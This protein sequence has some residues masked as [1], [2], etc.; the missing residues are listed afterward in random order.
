M[1]SDLFAMV[2]GQPSYQQFRTAFAA[3]K[4]PLLVVCGAGLSAPAGLPLWGELRRKLEINAKSKVESLNQFGQ[5]YHDGKLQAAI[6]TNDSWV[7]LKLISEILGDATFRNYVVEYLTPAADAQTPRGYA[8]LMRLQPRGVV[9]LNLD[10]FAGSAVSDAYPG[11]LVKPIFG[12]ELGRS[13][14]M[15]HDGSHYLVYLHGE[16]SETRSWGNCSPYPGDV[17]CG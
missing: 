5:Q 10:K 14:Q 8:A 1:T 11:M 12:M 13:W 2:R 3:R 4:L 16:L 17:V 15:L 7:A 9:T 6:S